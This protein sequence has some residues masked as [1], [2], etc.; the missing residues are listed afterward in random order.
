LVEGLREDVCDCIIFRGEFP[1]CPVK[2]RHRQDKL[3]LF[4]DDGR[5][6]VLRKCGISRGP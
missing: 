5:A 4:V 1:L 6:S 2:E 3:I